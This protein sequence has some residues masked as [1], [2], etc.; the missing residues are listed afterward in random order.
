MASDLAAA[1]QKLVVA[2]RIATVIAKSRILID[3]FANP[4]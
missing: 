1:V 3:D 4:T 2:M